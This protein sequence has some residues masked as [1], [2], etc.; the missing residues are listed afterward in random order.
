VAD[1]SQRSTQAPD[2]A[3]TA[4]PFQWRIQDVGAPQFQ[5]Q[6]SGL[7]VLLEQTRSAGF[8]FLSVGGKPIRRPFGRFVFA[9]DPDNILVEFAEPAA[10]R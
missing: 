2:D 4:K 7:D 5:L 9:I 6:V 3:P 1:T 8:R 10:E